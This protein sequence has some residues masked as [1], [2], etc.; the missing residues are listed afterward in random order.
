M[1]RDMPLP[2][3]APAA[4]GAIQQHLY[5][6]R[7]GQSVSSRP[8][9]KLLLV[10]GSRPQ[11]M[12]VTAMLLR[13]NIVPT[14]ACDGLQAVRLA[15]RRHF[16]CILMDLQLPVVD[17]IVA[18]ALIRQDQ[19]ENPSRPVTPVVAYTALDLGA[20]STRLQRVGWTAVL[21]KPCTPLAL[22]NCLAL[23]CPDWHGT[24]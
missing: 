24:N 14:M 21:H 22:R 5:P 13:W 18:T 3:S 9:L 16:D 8:A 20:V 15:E 6:H 10:D 11:R 17:G 1:L 23:C 12:L 4:H 7:H 2:S 19:R